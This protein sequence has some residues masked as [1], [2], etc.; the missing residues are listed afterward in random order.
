[1]HK[2]EPV[3]NN[4]ANY[5]SISFKSG[6]TCFNSPPDLVIKGDGQGAVLLQ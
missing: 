2:L 5:R 3:I 1:M 4:G 6:G